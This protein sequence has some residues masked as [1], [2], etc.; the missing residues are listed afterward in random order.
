MLTREALSAEIRDPICLF[1]FR[2]TLNHRQTSFVYIKYPVRGIGHKSSQKQLSISSLL[3]HLTLE[4]DILMS[5]R[6]ESF[7]FFFIK[8]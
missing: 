6:T 3:N 4:K 8:A 2:P 7:G 5:L 1:S